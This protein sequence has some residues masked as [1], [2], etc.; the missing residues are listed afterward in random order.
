MIKAS[1][2]RELQI[3]TTSS[4]D[5]LAGKVASGS[6]SPAN[7]VVEAQS[8]LDFAHARAAV[9]GS[10]HAQRHNPPTDIAIRVAATASREQSSFLIGFARDL[11]EGRYKPKAQGGAGAGQR[12]ARFALYSLRL[13]GTA[14][15]AWK[16][17]LIAQDDTIEALWKRHANESCTDCIRQASY[18]WRPLAEFRFMPGEGNTRCMVRC[19]CTV[20]TR[21]GQESYIL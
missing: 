4:L 6:L 21:N 18:G 20:E 1:T 15:E 8:V 13:G 19:R 9:L 10:F 14:N 5:R 7:F 12:K 17:T 11:A 3:K 16:E 2:L